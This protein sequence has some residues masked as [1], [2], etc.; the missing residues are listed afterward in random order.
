MAEQ[1]QNGF[2]ARAEACWKMGRIGQSTEGLVEAQRLL[3]D[4]QKAGDLEA[5]AD[6]NRS[7]GWF[8]LQLGYPDKGLQ[9]A[10]E[11]RTYF[12]GSDNVW[13]Y[14]LSLAVYSWLLLEMGLSDLSFDSAAQSVVVAARTDDLALKAFALN[15]KAI[16][17]I[18]CREDELALPMLDE[19]LDLAERSGDG[20]TIALTLVN[21]GYSLISQ[22]ILAQSSGDESKVEALA[23]RGMAANDRAIEVAR[24][25]GDLWNLRVA[26]CNGAETYAAQG[27]IDLAQQYLGELEQLPGQIGPREKIHYLYTKGD[28]L[29]TLG[30][31]VAAIEAY[32]EAWRLASNIA[33]LDHKVNT[34]RRLS[35]VKAKLGLH[36][37]ALTLFR[38]YHDAYVS[39]SGEMS[40]RRAHAMDMQMQNDKLREKAAAL[41]VQA[42]IDALTGVPNRR[43]FDAAFGQVGK[44]QAVLGILDVDHFKQV[45]DRY[46]HLVGDAVLAC[47]AGV[48]KAIDPAM[49]VFRIGGEEFALLFFGLSLDQA[50]RLANKAI[51]RIRQTDLSDLARGLRVTASV[52]LAEYGGLAGTKLLAEADRRLYVAKKLGR[53]RVI[54]DG[55]DSIS[56]AAVA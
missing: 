32:Q 9:P 28:L 33:H 23:A 55:R 44:Q 37:E 54:A 51:E 30:Q 43:A 10:S 34:L 2:R 29:M 52:G 6:A 3:I 31:D 4:A 1:D 42:G 21:T 46:S 26:L 18:M 53:D 11:A 14:G 7:I 39:Q 5:V 41:E 20:S 24:E 22:S 13:A 19:A 15:C 17:L 47:V 45:N 40:R 49:Q 16:S 35:D 36:E 25:A 50:E 12:S 8:C 56:A 27:R 38:A 48:V